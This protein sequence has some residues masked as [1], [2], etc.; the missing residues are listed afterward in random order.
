MVSNIKQ[1]VRHFRVFGCTS[2]FKRY[3]ISKGGKR[4]KNKCI[5]QG[6]RGIF[7]DFPEDTS[8]CLFYVPSIR[9]TYISL[10]AVFDE[11]FTSP[12][13]MPDSQMIRIIT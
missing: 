2:T 10:D 12:L 5:Q 7:V 11:N 1:S 3:E 8:G 13:S 4:I 6:I 9:K